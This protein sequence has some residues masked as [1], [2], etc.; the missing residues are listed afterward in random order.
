MD[1]SK[2]GKEKPLSMKDLPAAI[3]SSKKLKQP[4]LNQRQIFTNRVEG[5]RIHLT[6]SMFTL[7][8]IS[9]LN[10]DELPD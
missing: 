10:Y 4:K 1:L 8:F 2:I 9:C 5:E 3:E 6:P 7:W